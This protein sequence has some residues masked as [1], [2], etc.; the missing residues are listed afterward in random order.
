MIPVP[1]KRISR[2]SGSGSET[3]QF[4]SGLGAGLGGEATY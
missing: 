2:Q 3:S 4:A 1:E